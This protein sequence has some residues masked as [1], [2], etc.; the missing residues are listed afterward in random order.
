MNMFIDLP[1]NLHHWLTHVFT[2]PFI[3][4][5]T[6]SIP[7]TYTRFM[8]LFL[9]ISTGLLHAFSPAPIPL[10]PILHTFSTLNYGHNLNVI[11]ILSL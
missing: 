10:A 7:S 4:T 2:D 1:T 8:R 9:P 6:G 11:I 3:A 5:A